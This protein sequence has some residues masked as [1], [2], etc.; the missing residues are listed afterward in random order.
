MAIPNFNKWVVQEL[1]CAD[2]A[3]TQYTSDNDGSYFCINVNQH[4]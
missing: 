4:R 2:L 1:L 3:K